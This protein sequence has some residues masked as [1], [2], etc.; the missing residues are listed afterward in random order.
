MRLHVPAQLGGAP[1]GAFTVAATV[2][3]RLSWTATGAPG[4]GALGTVTRTTEIPVRVAEIQAL[5]R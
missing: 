5:N 1:G 4:G 2:T 3:W